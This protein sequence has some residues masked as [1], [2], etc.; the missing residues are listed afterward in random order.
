ML[1]L[2]SVQGEITGAAAGRCVWKGLSI[3]SAHL[4]MP[5]PVQKCPKKL[6]IRQ[7]FQYKPLCD[8]LREKLQLSLKVVQPHL[9]ILPVSSRKQTS[10]QIGFDKY[11]VYTWDKEIYC[12]WRTIISYIDRC[13]KCFSEKVQLFHLPLTKPSFLSKYPV[14]NTS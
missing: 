3:G 6:Q 4:P 14:Q 1:F 13:Y 9:F 7:L 5:G 2:F 11:V 8:K 12:V 10:R